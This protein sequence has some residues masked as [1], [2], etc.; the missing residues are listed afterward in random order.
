MVLPKYLFTR[1]PK[2]LGI[3]REHL[4]LFPMRI[5]TYNVNGIRAAM[6]KGFADWAKSSKADIICV[7]EIKAKEDQID[8]EALKKAGYDAYF[9][10]AEKPGY[11]GV[12]IL[13]RIKPDNIITGSGMKAYDD[14]GRAIRMDLGEYTLV[15][16]YFPSGTSGEVRQD[17]K[18]KFLDEMLPWMTKLKQERKNLIVVGDYNIAHTERDIHNPKGNKNTSGF[19]PEERAWLDKWFASG[20][21]DSFRYL[22]PEK[23]EYSWWS[24]RFNARAQNK[25]WRIDYQSVT[26]P[27]LPLLKESRHLM[28]VV[29]SDHC[30]VQLDIKL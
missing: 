19:L 17:V 11:S 12:G 29:H 13:T 30:P 8:T 23:V 25:G 28:E 2:S 10:P 21:H 16:W 6:N 5:I 1:I 9:F 3:L 24:V 14:E 27:L 26:D 20:V 18:M 15:N 4:P 7:Q 22:N